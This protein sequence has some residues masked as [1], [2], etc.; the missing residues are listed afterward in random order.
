MRISYVWFSILLFLAGFFHFIALIL[1]GLEANGNLP[2]ST[3]SW[4]YG[5]TFIP[6]FLEISVPV[7]VKYDNCRKDTGDQTLQQNRPSANES[8]ETKKPKYTTDVSKVEAGP[9]TIEESIVGYP[10]SYLPT[11]ITT[12]PEYTR[13]PSFSGSLED[14]LSFGPCY[15]EG[16]IESLV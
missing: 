15:E 3:V 9:Y 14:S 13:R 8:H 7:F 5:L 10:A 4:S 16:S 6:F 11:P 2:E 1:Y 12:I